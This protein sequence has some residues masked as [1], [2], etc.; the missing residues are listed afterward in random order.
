MFPFIKNK[1]AV[2]LSMIIAGIAIIISI[3]FTLYIN[4]V[5]NTK[6]KNAL[7]STIDKTTGFIELA[8]A[9]P[10]W[11]LNKDEIKRLTEGMLNTTEIIAVNIFNE[12]G[13]FSGY[14]KTKKNNGFIKV[15]LLK[16]YTP[17]RTD[18]LTRSGSIIK[19]NSTIGRFELYYTQ[20]YLVE[21]VNS[22]RLNN[23]YFFVFLAIFIIITINMATKYIIINP[24]IDLANLTKKIAKRRDYSIKVE[25]RGDDELSSLYQAFDDMITQIR[26]KE[27]EREILYSELK[28]SEKDYS[29]FFSEL[30]RAVDTEDYSKK[31]KFDSKN[32]ELITSLDTILSTLQIS[33][34]ESKNQNWLKS[35]QAELSNLISGE[36]EIEKL[37]QNAISFTAEYLNI[38]IAT[39]YIKNGENDNFQLTATYALKKERGKINEFKAGEGLIGQVALT[40][41]HLIL[42]EIPP[43]YMEIESSL[44]STSPNN[45]LIFPLIYENDVKGII[46]LG[47]ISKFTPLQIEF[48]KTISNII[49]VV[50]N[51]AIFS[52]QL[53]ELLVKTKEQAEELKAQQDKLQITNRELQ[54]QTKILKESEERLQTQQEELQASNEE[55]EEKNE[56]LEKQKDEIEKKN[57]IL[58][59]KQIELEE[60]ARQLELSTKYKS[61]FLANMSHELRTPLNSLLLLAR[62]LSDNEENNLSEDQIESASSIYR[63]GKNLLRLI[64]DILDLS[65]IEARKIELD[66]IKFKTATLIS[67]LKGEF[68]HVADNK[69][70]KLHTTL[71]NDAP[72]YLISDMHRLEQIIRNLVG[73]SLKFTSTG[74]VSI[75]I[76]KADPSVQLTRDDLDLKNTVAIK[77][78]DTGPGIALEKQQLIFEAFKQ[79]DGSISRMHGGTGLGLS[80]SKE[81]IYLIGGEI[82]VSSIL[83]EGAVF[84]IYLP[85]IYSA[86]IVKTVKTSS[87][88]SNQP[89]KLTI[90]LPVKKEN[91]KEEITPPDKNTILI[92]EDDNDFAN[93]IAKFSQKRG[94][95]YIIAP[96]GETGIDYAY[97]YNP[98]AIILDIGLPGIDGWK[99]LDELKNNPT[100][101]HIPVHIMSGKDKNKEILLKG[102]VG[103]LQKPVQ[104]ED[105]T[106]TFNKIEKIKEKS[107]KEL[108]IVEDNQELRNS[109]LKLMDTNDINAITC[110]SGEKAFE[111]L[112]KN[113]F[114]CVI[115]DLG[116][117]DISGFELLDRINLAENIDKPPII[118]YTGKELTQ[119]ET[120][121]LNNYSSSI[122]LK[123]AASFDRLLDET[124]LFMHRIESDLP[125]AQQQII[126]NIRD[127]ESILNKKR[128]LIVDDDMRNAFAL[129]KFLKSKGMIGTI[130]S[131]GQ[132]A[133]EILEK[134]TPPNIILMD[135]MMPV[136]DGYE[137]IKRIRQQDKFKHTPILALTAKAME[138]DRKKCIKCGASDYLTKPVDIP[139]LLSMLRVWLY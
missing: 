93:V 67:N 23:I 34:T 100:T 81:L 30:K 115:L 111:L 20:Q 75:E 89:P 73:N 16:P 35:G 7:K 107:I 78:T 79:V 124:A 90:P 72:Q 119:E 131:N 130:A 45:I 116:L 69:G 44:G 83:G 28:Q 105:I 36:K 137:T 135:I 103:Y 24:V 46:E 138:S 63:S 53:Q 8:Y 37:S 82:T 40:K 48:C 86:H 17:S 14:Q 38:P 1:I 59:E 11:N 6:S 101:R 108:L 61:E 88:N 97:K 74:F 121:K 64:N 106:K 54:N 55:M 33:S 132:K 85:E 65:K 29:N 91:K 70:L 80:I 87:N 42:N 32:I 77:I 136:M 12:D 76:S 128:V 123:K 96:N 114:D 133:L 5:N 112:S 49:A 113:K 104:I 68:K 109:I 27:N 126:R 13:F 41:K 120:I 31:K 2:K 134:T 71:N 50:I 56:I 84:T 118:I 58:R 19:G 26:S 62:M 110:A 66:I 98:T 94:Y 122:V 125:E 92:I 9:E 3:L 129:N 51:A 127:K 117:P 43:N 10:L 139:K 57:K 52:N 15:S 4:N 47:S 21:E 60:K 22:T 102:A 18:I 99:V 95:K 25:K 39:I